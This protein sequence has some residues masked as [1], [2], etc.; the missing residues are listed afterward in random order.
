VREVPQAEIFPNKSQPNGPQSITCMNVAF[1][2]SERGPYNYDVDSLSDTLTGLPLSAGVLI[3]GSLKDPA[4][5]WGGIMRKIETSDFEASN[6][7]F[8]QFWMMDPF[9]DGSLNV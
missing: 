9:A 5:R 3:D 4:T 2:P 6:I 7:E 8:I 1:Y